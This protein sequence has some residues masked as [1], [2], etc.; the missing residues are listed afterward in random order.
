MPPFPTISPPL[1]HFK[2]YPTGKDVQ[3]AETV[4]RHGQ[5]AD[6]CYHAGI[7]SSLRQ[8][9]NTVDETEETLLVR[10]T[11]V[12]LGKKHTK[13]VVSH[14][15]C[16][17]FEF[18]SPAVQ[19]LLAGKIVE[20]A[21]GMVFPVVVSDS[22]RIPIQ[23]RCVPRGDN[24]R[25]ITITLRAKLQFFGKPRFD[26]VRI[27]ME[28]ELH[29]CGRHQDILFARCLGFFRD[30]NDEH[31]VAV[32]YYKK[33]GR[34][35]TDLKTRLTKVQPEKPSLY[36]SYDILPVGAILNGALLVQDRGTKQRI[37]DPPQ[38]W[39]RQSPREHNHLIHFYGQKPFVDGQSQLHRDGFS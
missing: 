37:G 12:E 24:K 11:V 32:H 14:S 39:V 6:L 21:T 30:K 3:M 29:P 31:F 13:P 4:N 7:T 27:L 16:T 19:R 26:N 18:E 20:N 15:G 10:T 1:T 38:F 22:M 36:A 8:G 17:R 34:N 5:V 25:V 9:L 2:P 28:G 35:L 23:N 33:V